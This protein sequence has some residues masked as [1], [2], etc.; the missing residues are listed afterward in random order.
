MSFY[1]DVK[2]RNIIGKAIPLI[3]AGALSVRKSDTRLVMNT[4]TNLKGI[5]HH[6]KCGYW[7]NCN[8]WSSIVFENIIKTLPRDEWFVPTACQSCFKVVIRPQKLKALFAV[9]KIQ[10]K[11]DLQS[12]SGM[13]VRPGV[14]GSFGAYWYNRTLADGVECYKKVRLAIDEDEYLGP[15]IK[16]YEEKLGKDL[17]ILKRGCTEYEQALGASDKW[18]LSKKNIEFDEILRERIV[19]DNEVYQQ[20]E[21]EI[22]HVHQVWMETAWALGDETVYEYTDGKPLTPPYVTYHHL[23]DEKPKEDIDE[24]KYT[25]SKGA[26]IHD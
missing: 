24:P 7:N 9:E 8:L 26:E 15:H 13:E 4:T 23:A 14:F 1:E 20:N 3:D 10:V 2:R 6:I 19:I 12:K 5:W 25:D 18:T 11:M 17:V 21:I 22:D 16:E